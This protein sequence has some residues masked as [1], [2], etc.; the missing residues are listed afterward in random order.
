MRIKWVAILIGGAIALL[1]IFCLISE[2]KPELSRGPPLLFPPQ[3]DWPTNV[4]AAIVQFRELSGKPRIDQSI[5]IQSFVRQYEIALKDGRADPR[6][7]SLTKD[8]FRRLLGP[9]DFI[10]K[11]LWGYTLTSTGTSASWLELYFSNNRLINMGGSVSDGYSGS[12]E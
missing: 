10:K 9:P 5:E 7:N 4:L 12:A 1:M 2:H 3:Q 8:D 6:Y 11:Y